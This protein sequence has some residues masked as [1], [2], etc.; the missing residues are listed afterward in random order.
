MADSIKSIYGVSS[1]YSTLADHTFPTTFV[2]LKDSDLD[3]I[4]QGINDG[5]EVE[6]LTARIKK[7]QS[8]FS[9]ATF[10]FADTTAP[11]DTPRFADKKGAV[12]SAQSAW[13][14]LVSSEKVK[15]AAARKEFE[16]ICVRPFR[17]MTYPREFRLFVYNGE[18]KLM[19][20][21]HLERPYQRLL[22]RREFWWDKAKEFV[23]EI[24]WLLPQKTIVMDIYFTSKDDIMIV[25]FNKWGEPTKTLLAGTWT[26]DWNAQYG[27]KLM[28]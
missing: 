3:I 21:M 6:S 12:H 22:L 27:L 20:Q 8:A 25:D 9:G 5:S 26:L 1:W 17:N 16:F 2:K 23:D 10:V 24:S 11:T 14:N 4:A 28:E 13:N 7:A 19:S 18:L 15:E